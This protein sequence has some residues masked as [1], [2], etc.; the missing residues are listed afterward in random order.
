MKQLVSSELNKAIKK[1]Q[2]L[3]NDNNTTLAIASMVYYFKK[4][5]ETEEE[6]WTL[7]EWYKVLNGIESVH[8]F[9]GY[10]TKELQEAR[11][12]I[13]QSLLEMVENNY[14]KAISSRVNS[15]F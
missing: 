8:C 15:A 11:Y 10:I 6:K 2:N 1:A 13:M 4:N 5:A 12:S 7:S 3:T 14:G 9:I